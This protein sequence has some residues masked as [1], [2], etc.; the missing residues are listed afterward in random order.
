[1][2]ILYLT[3]W[4]RS[5]STL[6]GNLLNELPGVLHVGE[7]HYL[8]RNGVLAAG[9]NSTCGCGEP[10]GDCPLWSAVLGKA[11]GDA[12]AAVADQRAVLRTRHAHRRRT[13][14]APSARVART[15]ERMTGLYEAIA[16]ESGASVIVDS[17]KYPAEPALL[18][19]A[20]DV[21]LRVLHVVRDPRATAHSWRRAKA[22]IPAMGAARSTAYWTGFGWASD[23]LAPVLGERWRRLR[24]EDFVAA[25]RE[26]LAEIMRLAGID[27]EPPVGGDGTAALGVNHTV[28]G[29]P[30]RLHRGPVRVADGEAWRRELPRRDRAVATLLAA[31]LLGRYGYR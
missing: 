20:P 4:C 24:Y 23:R 25:P 27:G 13:E 14:R 17:S 6:I 22:Y 12:A 5:G 19:R 10:I 21:D 26:R 9:T 18:A 7:L 29:N 2:K 28:T 1:M 3:G 30:D 8:W 31:P 15:R 16:A 11:G